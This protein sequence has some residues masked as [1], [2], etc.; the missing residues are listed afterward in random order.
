MHFT[1]RVIPLVREVS[2]LLFSTHLQFQLNNDNS[3]TVHRKGPFSNFIIALF[4]ELQ[5]A[6]REKGGKS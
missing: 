1:S 4:K 6:G 5:I 3:L 2:I